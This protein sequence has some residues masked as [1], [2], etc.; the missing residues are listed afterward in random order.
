MTDAEGLKS[1]VTPEALDRVPFFHDLDA[2]ER[3]LMA[4]ISHR[5]NFARGETIFEEGKELDS[6]HVLASGLVSLR[7]QQK[8]GGSVITLGSVSNAGEMFGVSGLVAERTIALHSAVCLEDTETIEVDSDELLD[9][10][11]RKPDVGVRILRRLGA[12]MAE[13]LIAAREQIRSRIRPGLISHG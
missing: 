9:L 1:M 7:Q 5:R 11:E 10:C 3:E 2:E 6:L 13:R 12:I 4:P 8:S